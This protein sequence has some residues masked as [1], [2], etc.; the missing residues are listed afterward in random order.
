MKFEQKYLD[1]IKAYYDMPDKIE[2]LQE[3]KFVTDVTDVT[4][5]R[6]MNTDLQD[7]LEPEIAQYNTEKQVSTLPETVTSV[8]SVTEKEPIE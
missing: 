6:R 4:V 3:P 5:S 7:N 2:I 1:K 8:T